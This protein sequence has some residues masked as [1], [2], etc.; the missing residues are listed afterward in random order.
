MMQ[1][2]ELETGDLF[3]IR[4]TDL[5]SASLI[6]LQPQSVNF[7]DIS[8]P[9]A[10]L[11]KAF[12]DFSTLTKG[13]IFSFYYNDTVYDVAVLEVKPAPEKMGVSILETDVSVDFAPP[14]GYVEPSSSRAS[15]S[16]T[17]TPRSAIGGLP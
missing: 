12:R 14:L 8:N 10:V 15:V 3:Q 11:E 2:L 5:P 6:K 1:T 13:D 9:K 16:G 17:S 7:L 4:S